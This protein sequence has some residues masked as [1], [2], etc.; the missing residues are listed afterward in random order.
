MTQLRLL[1]HQI[2]LQ[3]PRFPIAFSA[4]LSPVL[5]VA[6]STFPGAVALGPDGDEHFYLCLCLRLMARMA[7]A[8]PVMR[9]LMRGLVRQAEDSGMEVPAEVREIVGKME[10]AANGSKEGEMEERFP[11][12]LE[13]SALEGERS[14]GRGLVEQAGRLSII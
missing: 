4:L 10:K 1:T 8:Y 9:G 12:L 7:G 13:L 11:V 14:E 6:T 3:Y 5:R 2:E